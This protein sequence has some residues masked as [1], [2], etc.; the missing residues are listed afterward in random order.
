MHVH[1][2]WKYR[3]ASHLAHGQSPYILVEIL[4][5]NPNKVELLEHQFEQDV[6]CEIGA[7]ALRLAILAFVDESTHIVD[8][9]L[10]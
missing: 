8:A 1:R 2:T 10:R 7:F 9:V 5:D 4:V 3:I 6:V